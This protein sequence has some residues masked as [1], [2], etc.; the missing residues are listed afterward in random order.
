ME[1]RSIRWIGVGTD[2]YDATVALFGDILGM[3]RRFAEPDTVEF[4]TAEGDAVQVM[5]PGHPYHGF[6]DRHASG[7]VPLL[8]VDDL[9][10]ARAR[11]EAAGIEI[12]GPVGRDREWE[13]INF[14]GPDGN[15]YELGA[16][17]RECPAP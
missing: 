4:Q 9:D 7:P 6:F 11:L 13:W 12:L 15:L 8:E 14:R 1:V 17:R 16:R 3:E 10:A 2:A 5:A